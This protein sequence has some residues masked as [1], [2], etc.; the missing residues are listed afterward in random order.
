MN[1]FDQYM[2]M[3]LWLAEKGLGHVA[4]NPMVGCVIVHTE[5][6]IIGE[7]YH[8]RY[9]E[10]HAEVNAINSVTDKGLLKDSTLYVNLEPCSHYGKTPPCCDL[11]IE[12]KIKRI[13]IGCLDSNPL[14]AGKGIE[15]LRNTGIEV[16][17][18]ILRDECRE[19]NKR[20][21]TF[22]E[23][24]RPY[25]ILKWAQTT[26]GFIS[27]LLPFTKQEN[28]I[29]NNESDKLVH[30][31]RAQEQAILVGTN[32]A[33]FDNPSLTVRLAEGKNPLRVLIDRELKVPASNN[34]FSK[35][36]ETIVFTEKNQNNINNVHYYRID[37][38]RNIIPQILNILFNQKILSVIIEGGTHT[39]ENF[40]SQGLWD[41]ARVL[42]GTIQFKEG[43]KAPYIKINKSSVQ[44]IEG[45]KLTIFTQ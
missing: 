35:N 39:L 17:T 41:E 31:W 21:F 7:G 13:I 45:D 26:D 32:T 3:C 11:I 6:G 9:G 42:T 43:I 20:F 40:I 28:H 34:I 16:I 44:M 37:F 2:L 36:A 30:A 15:K 19:L 25:V 4:P 8:Q 23:K 14:V 38:T 18:D 1:E 12:Y 29:T 24:K 27:K 22:H 5:K 33:L 10:A